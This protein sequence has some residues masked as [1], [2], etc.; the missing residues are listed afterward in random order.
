MEASKKRIRSGVQ[1]LVLPLPS[2]ATDELKLADWLELSALLTRKGKSSRGDLERTI[3]RSGVFDRRGPDAIEAKCDDA[4]LE[5]EARAVSAGK[6]YPFKIKGGLVTARGSAAKFPVYVF[7]LCLSYFGWRQAVA[8]IFPARMFEKL[9]SVAVKLYLGGD[10][11]V[12]AS[13]RDELPKGFKEALETVCQR[14]REGGG[15]KP[16][17]TQVPKDDTV[18]VIA[19]KAFP[20]GRPGQVLIF[21]QCATGDDLKSKVDR[22]C[23][24]PHFASSGW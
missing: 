19:W 10:V 9:S 23:R 12:F 5:L 24:P 3:R 15:Y 11:L 17:A 7:C 6:A 13:P 22:R 20:D 2:D 4:F 16:Q 8:G 18:D 1:N 21:G 14:I